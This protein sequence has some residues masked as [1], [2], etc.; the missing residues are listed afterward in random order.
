MQ[1]VIFPLELSVFI[2]SLVVIVGDQ[3]KKT[4]TCVTEYTNALLRGKGHCENKSLPYDVTNKAAAITPHVSS[5][6]LSA[7][8]STASWGSSSC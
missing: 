7:R 3:T 6:S 2:L 4:Q 1:I 8:R 5:L